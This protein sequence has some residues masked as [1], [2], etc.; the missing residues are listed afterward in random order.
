MIQLLTKWLKRALMLLWV[1]IILVLSAN[2]TLDNPELATLH[3]FAVN[4][5]ASI[6]F[7]LVASFCSGILLGIGCVLPVLYLARLRCK[8]A[9][10]REI[11]LK[12]QLD[13]LANKDVPA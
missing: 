8:R 1:L 13:Q 7:L 12:A 10:Q 2:I 5:S 6:G 11:M 9:S 4:F 3:L